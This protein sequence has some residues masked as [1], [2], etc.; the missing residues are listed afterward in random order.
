MTKK[1]IYKLYIYKKKSEKC[2]LSSNLRD[3]D[4]SH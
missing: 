1:E 2:L 3:T 4:I